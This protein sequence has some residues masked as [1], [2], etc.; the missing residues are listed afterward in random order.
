MQEICADDIDVNVAYWHEV[1]KG[2]I[3]NICRY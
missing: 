1:T 3:L 2:V